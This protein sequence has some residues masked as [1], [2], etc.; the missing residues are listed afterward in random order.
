MVSTTNS[1]TLSPSS[2]PN[3]VPSPI[4]PPIPNPPNPLSPQPHN[5]PP[6]IHP[7]PRPLPNPSPPITKPITTPN[8][9]PP[10]TNAQLGRLLKMNFPQFNEEDAQFWITCATN[11]FDMYSV[12]PPMW[13]CVATMHFTGTAKRGLQSVKHSL[14]TVDWSSFCA[15]IHERFSLDQHE[16]FLRQLF[17]IRQTS[18]VFQIC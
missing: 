13:V 18:T 12:E 14:A 11:Y 17:H 15:M 1:A 6:F 8:C 16:L 5:L 4:P 3:S 10:N 2:S 9:P 7:I